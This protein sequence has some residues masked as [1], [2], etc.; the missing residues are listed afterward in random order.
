MSKGKRALK[1]DR[2]KLWGKFI[3]RLGRRTIQSAV[4]DNLPHWAAAISYYSVMSFAPMVFLGISIISF[5]VDAEWTAER[6]TTI[7]SNFVPEG[8]NWTSDLVDSALNARGQVSF[9]SA[10][11][12]LYTGSRVFAAL[13]RGLNVVY[14][15]DDQKNF[16]REIAVQ[17]IMLFTIGMAFIAA[18][19]SGFLFGLIWDAV[20]ILPGGQENLARRLIIG[21]LQIVALFIGYFLIYRFVP[22]GK[23]SNDSAVLG[24][25]AATLLF[26]IVRPLF[27]FYINRFGEQDVVYG[28][29][30][31][32][33]VLLLWVW[34]AS[35]IILIGA[36][37]AVNFREVRARYLGEDEV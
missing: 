26:V 25:V 22:R 36:E 17:F 3:F 33:V 19:A 15:F 9:I 13:A 7:F 27:I 20:Q 23:R 10:I 8:S 5:F 6:L 14:D 28:P 35:L 37:I 2:A 11:A 16:L 24:A 18:L 30:A 12:F 21:G 4:E 32:L 31:T 29:L 1:T 34:I